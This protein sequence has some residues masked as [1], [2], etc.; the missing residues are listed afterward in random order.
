MKILVMSD[1]HGNSSRMYQLFKE[2]NPRAVIFLGDG[3]RD[4]DYLFDRSGAVPIYWVKG[5]CD[6]MT[7]TI[8]PEE[9]FLELSG[10]KIFITH[11]HNYFVKQG[12]YKLLQKAKE[13]LADVALFGHTHIQH[14]EKQDGII[15]ANP[16]ALAGGKYAI[17]TIENKEI[18]IKHGD[19][20]E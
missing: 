13:L 16:G 18:S 15:L 5:N 8:V 6:L 11:G 9:Q 7:G 19:I 2:Q 14:Y 20:Y 1:S 12:T 17:M 10:K 3:L 4:A